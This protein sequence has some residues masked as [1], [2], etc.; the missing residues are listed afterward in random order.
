MKPK[1]IDIKDCKIVRK[2]IKNA[3][4]TIKWN[5]EVILS[6]PRWY[7][8]FQIKKIFNDR[9]DWIES[10][11]KTIN[12]AKVHNDV[13]TWEIRLFG[14][15]YRFVHSPMLNKDIID[16]EVLTIS[17][18]NDL[19]DTNILTIWYKKLAKNY[20]EKRTTEIAWN[21]G[22][23]I[24]KITVR[25][26]KTRWWSCSSKNNISLNR[27]LIKC[28]KDVIDYVIYHELVHTVVKNHSLRFWSEL[29]KHFPSYKEARAWL[30]HNW[31]FHL[32]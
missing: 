21:E 18:K 31:G 1:L 12:K 22:F 26:Q 16:N 27:A 24:W 28:P 14:E 7:L 25:S 32:D 9:K 2:R 20:L 3:R 8:N 10:K 5:G 13:K 30:K 6:V 15:N 11:L 23:K 17:S 29:E 19:T 4:I